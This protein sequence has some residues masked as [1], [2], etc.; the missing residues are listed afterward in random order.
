MLAS[1]TLAQ[2]YARPDG[3]SA[4]GDTCS[5]VNLG[6]FADI[7]EVSPNDSDFTQCFTNVAGDFAFSLRQ[8]T[9]SPVTDPAVSTGHIV[10]YRCNS[11]GGDS[12]VIVLLNG[13]STQL[14]PF[15]PTCDGG[16]QSYTLSAAEANSI[17]DY[18]NLELR[19]EDT[20]DLLASC[21]GS[22]AG[23]N[24]YWAEFEVPSASG[25]GGS[26]RVISVQ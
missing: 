5:D 21:V 7:D 2:Q 8:Y 13:T 24:V 3:A 4:L 19:F 25:G 20:C 18:T 9:L 14:A 1:P 26:R 12:P 23:M 15:V 10:R 6:T 11:V 17:T 16:T 22:S